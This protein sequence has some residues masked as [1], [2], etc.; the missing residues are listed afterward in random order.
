MY[1][2]IYIY[3]Y[4]YIERERERDNTYIYI[5]IER[6]RDMLSISSEGRRFPPSCMKTERTE[7]RGLRT[8]PD[9]VDFL[10]FIVF[11]WAETLAH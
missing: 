8:S 5:Y 4:I 9:T 2:Y 7:T 11:F 1:T 6:E 10:N 3:I